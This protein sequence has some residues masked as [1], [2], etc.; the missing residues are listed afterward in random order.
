MMNLNE[1]VGKKMSFTDLD[2]KMMEKGFYSV[3]D[4]GVMEEIKESGNAYYQSGSD[5]FIALI[6]FEVVSNLEDGDFELFV[7]AAE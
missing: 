2:N 6:S 5:D 3:A 7:T 4:D 1:L